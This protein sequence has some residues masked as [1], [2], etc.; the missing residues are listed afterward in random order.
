MPKEHKSYSLGEIAMKSKKWDV[1]E[2]SVVRNLLRQDSSNPDLIVIR[3]HK[4]QLERVQLLAV[5]RRRLGQEEGFSK[6]TRL[7]RLRVQED[8]LRF[9]IQRAEKDLVFTNY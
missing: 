3:R 8:R 6:E 7:R 9:A 5:V 4:K 1:D 2:H